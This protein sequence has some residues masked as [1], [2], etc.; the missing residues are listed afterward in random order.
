MPTTTDFTLMPVGTI[1][2]KTGTFTQRIERCPACGLPGKPHFAPR[3]RQY[4]HESRVVRQ[5]VMAY[6]ATTRA[7]VVPQQ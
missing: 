3:G 4:V 1:L 5:G 6:T 2:M 7:C